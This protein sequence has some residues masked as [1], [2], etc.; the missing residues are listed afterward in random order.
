MIRN[1]LPIEIEWERAMDSDCTN[2]KG[3]LFS[4]LIC[5]N[6]RSRT[7]NA[8]Y[9]DSCSGNIINLLPNPEIA[10]VCEN[11]QPPLEKAMLGM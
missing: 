3:N 10:K 9:I 7:L 5:R 4:H 11:Q 1:R 8:N 6:E 2:L